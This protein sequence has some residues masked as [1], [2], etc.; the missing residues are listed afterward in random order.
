MVEPVFS[1]VTVTASGCRVDHDPAK[2]ADMFREHGAIELRGLIDPQFA[3]LLMA[4]I[5][6]CGWVRQEVGLAGSRL[7]EAPP[8]LLTK[9]L[10]LALS[11]EVFRDCIKSITGVDGQLCVDGELVQMQASNEEHFLSWHDDRHEPR[12][13][14]GFTINLS[15]V[16]YQGGEFEMRRK[17]GTTT[18]RHSH[19]HIGSM[20][21]FRVSNKD[22][23][24][25]LPVTA[26][27]P[28]RVFA[29]GIT[30]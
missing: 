30:N 20:L 21:L 25:V 9:A 27:G 19:M 11:G 2:L 3:T 14:L 7:V 28:R 10:R 17:G 15:E 18:Y 1:P 24:R 22:E 13:R 8:R 4:R 29:G 12:R 26:G 16:P 5:E 6:K 23:H